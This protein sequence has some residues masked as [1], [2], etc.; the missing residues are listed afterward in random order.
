MDTA[1]A[2]SKIK[3]SLKRLPIYKY[4]YFWFI[5]PATILFIALVC[6]AVYS[7][8]VRAQATLLPVIPTLSTA[9]TGA[10]RTRPRI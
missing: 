5:V 1:K 6:G 8:K 7:G 2:L 4:R 9:L 10:A 3:L